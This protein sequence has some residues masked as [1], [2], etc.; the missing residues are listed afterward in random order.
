MVEADKA[1]LRAY[2]IFADG[3]IAL[4][5]DIISDEEVI[6]NDIKRIYNYFYLKPYTKIRI[7]HNVTERDEGFQ[8]SGKYMG[9]YKKR[10]QK[11]WCKPLSLST[12]SQV[13][14]LFTDWKGISFIDIFGGEQRRLLDKLRQMRKENIG[15]GKQISSL[16]YE[17]IKMS[18][19]P[20]DYHLKN[21][22]RVQ[23][24]LKTSTIVVGGE[25][26]EQ[27]EEY[28]G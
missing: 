14:F 19:N 24:I 4:I 21:M 10:Y 18:K 6:E 12:R 8:N 26:K 7:E 17:F 15:L 22:E 23:K 1:N 16:Q 5:D 27:G 11:E 25:N 13:W 28:G 20:M 3:G 2:A 9:F